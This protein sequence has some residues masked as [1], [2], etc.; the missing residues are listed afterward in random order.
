MQSADWTTVV[1]PIDDSPTPRIRNA[2][3]LKNYGRSETIKRHA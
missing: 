3:Q 2:Q 1:N